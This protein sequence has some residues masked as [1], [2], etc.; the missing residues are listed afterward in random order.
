MEV[1]VVSGDISNFEID[2]IIVNLFE[3]VEHPGGATGAVDRALEG[4]ISRLIAEGEIKGKP[5]LDKNLNIEWVDKLMSQYKFNQAIDEIWKFVRAANKYIN[6]NEPWRL[7]GKELGHVLYNLLESI[8]IISILIS[9]FMPDTA[10]NINKQLGVKAG[11]LK[12]A[13]FGPFSG[14]VKKG[15]YLFE[16]VE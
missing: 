5:E 11:D 9:P 16:K 8:R 10:K 1:K 7:E 3:G 15:K 4:I 2:S 14:K 13:K 12:D 6:D